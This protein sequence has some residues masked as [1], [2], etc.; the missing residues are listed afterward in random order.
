VEEAEGQSSCQAAEWKHQV[1]ELHWY[2]AHGIGRKDMIPST[3]LVPL[4][5][6]LSL[7]LHTACPSLSWPQP[8]PETVPVDPVVADCW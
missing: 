6:S 7:L 1:V 5:S 3:F 2:E 4:F 8:G